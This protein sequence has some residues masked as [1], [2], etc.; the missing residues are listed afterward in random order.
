[1]SRQGIYF[2]RAL[3][4]D[5]F[6]KKANALSKLP[7]VEVYKADLLNR[8]SLFNAFMNADVI[9]GNTTPTKGWKLFQGSMVRK[10]ELA[11]G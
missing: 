9:Y 4:R 11:Q 7:N 3:T 6:S 2:I 10:Y 8:E 1:M 5:P